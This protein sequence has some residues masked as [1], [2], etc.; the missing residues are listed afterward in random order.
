LFLGDGNNDIQPEVAAETG[1]SYIS[2]TMTNR[3]EVS[4]ANL[5]FMNMMSLKKCGLPEVAMRP[6]KPETLIS[7]EL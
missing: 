2:E 1:N 6:T 4:T 7:L 3:I 5:G